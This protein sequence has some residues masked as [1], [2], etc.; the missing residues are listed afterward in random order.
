MT[1][2]RPTACVLDLRLRSLIPILR[3]TLL[4][5]WSWRVPTGTSCRKLSGEYVDMLA[6][7]IIDAAK[8]TRSALQNAAS[9]AGPLLTTEAVVADKPEEEKELAA[10]G[11]GAEFWRPLAP[12]AAVSR[13]P[14]TSPGGKADTGR[15]QRFHRSGPT[16]RLQR[17]GQQ[18]AMGQWPGPLARQQP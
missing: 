6:A 7:R 16:G 18:G 14:R 4:P 17:A 13:T 1:K 9:I 8:V 12:R 10:A 15:H 11:A 2:K 5:V 3:A